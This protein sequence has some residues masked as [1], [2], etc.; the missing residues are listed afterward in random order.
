MPLKKAFSKALLNGDVREI[1][2]LDKQ[3]ACSHLF[4]S[5]NSSTQ[6]IEK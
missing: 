1:I 3:I 2:K 4:L 5:F 6:L